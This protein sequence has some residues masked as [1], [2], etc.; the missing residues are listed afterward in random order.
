[1]L[2]EHHEGEAILSDNIGFDVIDNLRVVGWEIKGLTINEDITHIK[3]KDK[4]YS[5]RVF[6]I[7]IQRIAN[8]IIVK[9]FIPLL[10]ISLMAYSV[11]WID[12]SA[13]DAQIGVANAGLGVKVFESL[14]YHKKITVEKKRIMWLLDD[15][16]I[17]L[18]ELPQLGCFV[19][20]E[21]PD[22]DVISGVLE[23]LNLQNEPHI[24]KGYAAMMSRK[25]KQE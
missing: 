12:P 20:V 25:L 24:S 13:A 4:E 2:S 5:M 14:G 6:E 21:G 16:E 23:K 17:C 22:E 9:L 15:C 3:Y 10:F 8:N 7:R 18:D 11:F 19:E 1:M